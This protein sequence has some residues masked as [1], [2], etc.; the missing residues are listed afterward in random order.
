MKCILM[1]SAMA[2]SLLWSGVALAGER[3]ADPCEKRCACDHYPY[4]EHAFPYSAD[5]C[6]CCC[7]PST[8]GYEKASLS[9]I[10]AHKE[11]RAVSVPGTG[12][13]LD[14]EVETGTYDLYVLRQNETYLVSYGRRPPCPEGP[15]HIQVKGKRMFFRSCTDNEFD[16]QILKGPKPDKA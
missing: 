6:L 16:G 13:T 1:G 3:Q 4:R 12:A 7:A 8:E 9:K 15:I 5:Q 2:L 10:E 11:T 14:Q